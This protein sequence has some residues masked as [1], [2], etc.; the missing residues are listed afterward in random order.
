MRGG[1]RREGAEGERS[2]E[3]EGTVYW[4]GAQ[5]AEACLLP[6]LSGEGGRDG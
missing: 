5:P 6:G 2:G 1:V 3:A 4:E